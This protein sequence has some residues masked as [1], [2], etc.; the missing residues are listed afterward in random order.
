MARPE[1]ARGLASTLNDIAGHRHQ[2]HLESGPACVC[3]TDP[4][5]YL[6]DDAVA[7]RRWVT[8]IGT[9]QGP[10]GVV[11]GVEDYLSRANVDVHVIRLRDHGM[12]ERSGDGVWR[13]SSAEGWHRVGSALR[14]M[15][16]SLLVWIVSAIVL[17][18]LIAGGIIMFSD[19]AR[20]LSH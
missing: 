7:G 5:R 9:I 8:Q 17:A 1:Q 18:V 2:L 4:L 20:T 11:Y 10:R 14:T 13:S 16:G 3:Q 12:V 15:S 6:L 19:S